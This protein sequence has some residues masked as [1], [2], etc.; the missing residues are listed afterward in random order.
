M[1]EYFDEAHAWEIASLDATFAAR[2]EWP[3]WLLIVLIHGGWLAA[4]LCVHSGL[5]SMMAATPLLIVLCTWHMSLQHELLHGHPTRS[6]LVNKLLGSIPL[7]IWYPYAIY[8]DTHIAHHRDESLTEPNVDPESNY[9]LPEQW[10]NAP[11]WQRALWRMRKSFAG[12]L[13]AGPPL[14]V[15]TLLAGAVNEWRRGDQRYASTWIIHAALVTVLLAWLQLF[16]G[17]AWWYYLLAVTWPALSL[18]MIRSLYEHRAVRDPK[19]RTVINEAG[20]LMRLLYLNNNYHLV[21]HDLPHLPWY[22]LPH[23]YRIRRDAYAT[24]NGGFVIRGGYWELLKRFAVHETDFP[25]HPR[26]VG[27]V[28]ERR[29][30]QRAEPR[31]VV[32]SEGTSKLA[33]LLR[34]DGDDGLVV[35]F[36]KDREPPRKALRGGGIT[37]GHAA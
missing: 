28:A 21:H 15:V 29:A 9:V 10:M 33:V 13:I 34:P 20:L 25:V 7:A 6:A 5:L 4:V 1:A 23:A 18:A 36:A 35:A 22:H 14:S 26:L 19:H 16:A 27:T 24:K 17:I 37:T 30:P 32:A 12:R 11:A 3:T 31:E 2:T 8:R